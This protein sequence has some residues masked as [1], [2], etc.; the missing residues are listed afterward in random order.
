MRPSNIKIEFVR[1][2][3][4]DITKILETGR[5]REF[6][7]EYTLQELHAYADESLS[8]DNVVE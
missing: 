4:Q 2:F 7:E 8:F 5:H 3:H 6:F 1:K